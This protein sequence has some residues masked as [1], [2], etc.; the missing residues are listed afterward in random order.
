M[1]LR[2]AAAR[3]RGH[4]RRKRRKIVGVGL[5]GFAPASVDVTPGRVLRWLRVIS[6]AAAAVWH[7][8]RMVR[9]NIPNN[10]NGGSLSS[11]DDKGK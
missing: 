7:V 5:D 1:V 6:A 2:R 10:P 8:I 3:I 9:G 11:R 4:K